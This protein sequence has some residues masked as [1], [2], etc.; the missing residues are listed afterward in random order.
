MRRAH[1]ETVQQDFTT[2]VFRFSPGIHRSLLAG[3][4]DNVATPAA[5]AAGFQDWQPKVRQRHEIP[6][7]FTDNLLHGD[8]MDNVDAELLGSSTIR[9]GRHCSKR[10]FAASGTR[11]CDSYSKAAAAH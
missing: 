1:S 9:R 3:Q 11:I 8:Q 5:A 10:G 4:K 2:T 6:L 7:S